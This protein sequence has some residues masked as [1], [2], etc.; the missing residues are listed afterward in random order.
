[1][2]R[3]DRICADLD[4][5][6]VR[7]SERIPGIHGLNRCEVEIALTV[8]NENVKVVMWPC[9]TLVSVIGSR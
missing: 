6:V 8:H 2:R 4:P 9:S 7:A 1:M 5:G 3:V